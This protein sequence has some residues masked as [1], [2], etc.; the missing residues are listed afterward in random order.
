MKT[1]EKF[2]GEL[3]PPGTPFVL[4]T[5]GVRVLDGLGG[6]K[7]TYQHIVSVY[8]PDGTPLNA[9][10]EVKDNIVLSAKPYGM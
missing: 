2:I 10:I 6:Y 9:S 1:A 3:F 5:E 4:S 7:G 8:L